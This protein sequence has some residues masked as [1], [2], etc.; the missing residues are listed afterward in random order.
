[1]GFFATLT[2]YF[3][4]INLSIA[5]VAMTASNSSS[6]VADQPEFNWSTAEKADLLGCYYYGYVLTQVVGAW[7]ASKYGFKTI[8]LL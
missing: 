4:R 2:V 7:L 6:N 3:C 8:L 5:I 1:M